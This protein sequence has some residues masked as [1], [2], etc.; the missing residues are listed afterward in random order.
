MLPAQIAAYFGLID[1]LTSGWF[2]MKQW[3]VSHNRFDGI[4]VCEK[5]Y[6][7][8]APWEVMFRRIP[9]V[10]RRFFETMFKV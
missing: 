3:R 9:L 7:K 1:R 5:D 2:Y 6:P 10:Q 8:A 4:V